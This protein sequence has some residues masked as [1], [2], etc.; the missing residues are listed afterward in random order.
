MNHFFILLGLLCLHLF[1]GYGLLNL[2]EIKLRPWPRAALATITGILVASCVPFLLQLFYLPLT[3]KS[4][5]GSWLS[6]ALLLHIKTLK[7][8][9]KGFRVDIKSW[10]PRFRLYELPA[11]LLLCFMLFVSAWRCYY[12]PSYSRDGLS[13]PEAIAAYART[14][15]TLINSIFSLSLESTNNQFKSPFLTDLQRIYQLAGLPFGNVW[16]SLLVCSLFIFL[17]YCM[18]EKLHKLLAGI[19]LVCFLATPEA[20]AYTFICLYDYSNMILMFVGFYYLFAYFKSRK[21]SEFYF[22]ALLMAFAVFIRSETLLLIGMAMPL[23]LYSAFK[24]KEKW[25]PTMLHICAYLLICTLFYYVP[26]EIYNNHYLPQTYAI[27]NLMNKDL[28]NLSP[29]F[30]R[31]SDMFT[32]LLFGGF[33]I[34]LWGYFIYLFTVLFLAEL[35]LKRK[36]TREAGNWL[37]TIGI[38]FL[39]LLL[40]G[41]LFPLMDL[42]NTTKRG[43]FKLLP[44]LLLYMSNS[45]LLIGLSE[46]IWKWEQGQPQIPVVT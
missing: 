22:S 31:V 42:L 44:L 30:Q 20:Y 33:S 2:F 32:Q 10:I 45:Q 27:N 28:S 26:V 16:L 38:I 9:G 15:H 36:F 4:I 34:E 29:F 5:F 24:A 7:K 21:R 37:V 46:R 41:F 8:P 39:G 40:L 17:Y 25:L 3:T 19:L 18:T 12:Y 43:L 13:G 6:I 35:I 1:T 23:V 11:L 14:E